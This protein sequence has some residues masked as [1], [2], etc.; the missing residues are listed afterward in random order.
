MLMTR[1]WEVVVSIDMAEKS[2]IWSTRESRNPAAVF[3]A[4]SSIDMDR[5]CLFILNQLWG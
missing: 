3:A 1:F 5:D 2:E 4:D